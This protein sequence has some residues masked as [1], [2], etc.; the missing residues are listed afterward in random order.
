MAKSDEPN[1]VIFS[2]IGVSKKIDTAARMGMAVTFVM[3]VSSVCAFGMGLLDRSASHYAHQRALLI[4]HWCSE[5]AMFVE[6]SL[7]LC[8]RVRDRHVPRIADHDRLQS[9]IAGSEHQI[10]K[11]NDPQ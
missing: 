8:P 10:A 9:R 6:K 2:M 5:E 4:H 7:Q 1:K 11:T 3:L